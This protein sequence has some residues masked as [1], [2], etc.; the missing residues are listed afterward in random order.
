[1]LMQLGQYKFLLCTYNPR[2]TQ[3]RDMILLDEYNVD[4]LNEE[5]VSLPSL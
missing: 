1:M 4:Y 3:P 5:G 2:D